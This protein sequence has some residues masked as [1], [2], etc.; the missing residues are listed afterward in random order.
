MGPHIS[1]KTKVHEILGESFPGQWEA[2]RGAENPNAIH[3]RADGVVLDWRKTAEAGKGG[4][5]D[6]EPAM[7]PA[8]HGHVA[9]VT[10]TVDSDENRKVTLSLGVDYWMQ[11]WVNGQSAAKI[12]ETHGTPVP[13]AFKTD[14][15]LKKGKNIITLK[16]VSGSN[17]FGFW[18]QMKARDAAPVEDDAPVPVNFY[19]PLFRAF[20]PYL[21]TYW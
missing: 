5:V 10:R 14:V 3:K 13:N 21:F 20:D 12:D 4:Y 15:S 1:T 9:Y 2:I 6:L 7:G 11:V 16:V 18:C 19:A 8:R 17:G